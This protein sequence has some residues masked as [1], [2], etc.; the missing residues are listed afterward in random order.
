MDYLMKSLK[1]LME[2]SCKLF[3]LLRKYLR[4]HCFIVDARKL[5]LFSYTYPLK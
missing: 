2:L 1:I 4:Q 3:I 5:K